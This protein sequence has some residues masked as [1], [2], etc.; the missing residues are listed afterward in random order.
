MNGPGG[1]PLFWLDVFTDTP[2]LGNGLAVVLDADDVSAGTMLAFAQEVNL[3]ETTF[4]QTASEAGADYRNRIWTV[5]DELPFAG[6]PS[7]G[8]A[9]AV[10]IERALESAAFTQQTQVGLQEIEVSREDGL[11]HAAVHQGAAEFGP[12]VPTAKIAPGLG[13][14]PEQMDPELGG[15]IASTGLPALL[16]P[17]RDLDALA[18]CRPDFTVLKSIDD[19]P[20]VNAYAFV[21]ER[22]SRTVRARCFGADLAGIEDPATGSAAGPLLAYLQD[23]LDISEIVIEQGVEMGRTSHL[24]AKMVDGRPKVGGYVTLLS[25]GEVFLP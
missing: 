12:F 16:A 22:G 3:S 8:T 9:V 17:V 21:Y 13:L 14:T 19:R 20:E 6:H 1:R 18:A 15:Q 25:R 11:W 24:E 7:L 23:C 5:T 2:L 4:V 10:A